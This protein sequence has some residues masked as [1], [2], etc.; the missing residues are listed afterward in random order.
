MPKNRRSRSEDTTADWES[1]QLC[2]ENFPHYEGIKKEVK[3]ELTNVTA[4][5]DFAR[6]L[7]LLIPSTTSIWLLL[8]SASEDF[9]PLGPFNSDAPETVYAEAEVPEWRS[10]NFSSEILLGTGKH[11][12][13]ASIVKELWSSSTFA[14]SLVTIIGSCPESQSPP[15]PRGLLTPGGT[16]D[17]A[18]PRG[19][20]A[21]VIGELPDKRQ[22]TGDAEGGTAV[23]DEPQGTHT[24]SY[25]DVAAGRQAATLP[26]DVPATEETASAPRRGLVLADFM[27]PTFKKRGRPR[28]RSTRQKANTVATPAPPADEQPSTGACTQSPGEAAGDGT[29]SQEAGGGDIPAE[30]EV[31]SQSR[32]PSPPPTQHDTYNVF[33]SPTDFQYSRDETGS[34]RRRSSSASAFAGKVRQLEEAGRWFAERLAVGELQPDPA[35]IFYD[36]L[37]QQQQQDNE[38]SNQPRSKIL[39]YQ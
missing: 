5:R 17:T 34:S 28:K 7:T 29:T 33:R 30:P 24:V 25:A 13:F 9:L 11:D 22:V 39:R 31:T 16:E 10:W 4:N 12:E 1:S 36:L 21:G 14:E 8:Y 32:L 23:R 37:E 2:Y 18:E 3:E 26:P 20:S 35:A 15:S 38:E 27:T 19:G 6:L